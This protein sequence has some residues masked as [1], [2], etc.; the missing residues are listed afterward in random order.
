MNSPADEVPWR[1]TYGCF[2]SLLFRWTIIGVSSGGISLLPQKMAR[3]TVA[4]CLMGGYFDA[5][6]SGPIVDRVKGGGSQT[7]AIQIVYL[8]AP[9]RCASPLLRRKR[10]YLFNGQACA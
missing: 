6:V 10:R 7:S 2:G 3:L 8:V 4:P 1:D 9:V 5:V